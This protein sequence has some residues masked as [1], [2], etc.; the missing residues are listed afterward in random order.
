[1]QLCGV[2]DWGADSSWMRRWQTKARSTFIKQSS[3]TNAAQPAATHWSV[4]W[5]KIW[6]LFWTVG[7]SVGRWLEARAVRRHEWIR[8]PLQRPSVIMLYRLYV[9]VT[10]VSVVGCTLS[11]FNQHCVPCNIALQS[12]IMLASLLNIATVDEMTTVQQ[13]FSKKIVVITREIVIA[14]ITASTTH[15][16]STEVATLSRWHAA[17][18]LACT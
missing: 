12:F 11:S 4:S 15:W 17:V 8:G 10:V 7:R 18:L 14:D 3:L 9:T 16:T 2:M 6:L 1:M 13:T 5:R